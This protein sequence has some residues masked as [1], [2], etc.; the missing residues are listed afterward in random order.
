MNE[1]EIRRLI[2]IVEDTGIA[3][4]EVKKWWGMRVRIVRNGAYQFSPSA[5]P[6]QQ[7]NVIKL[8]GKA[9]EPEPVEEPETEYHIARS[10]MVGTFYRA[11]APGEEPFVSVGDSVKV[12]QT[13]CIIEAM[14]VMNE[15]EAECTGT[16]RKILI[17]N[18]QAV[19]F[20]QPLFY[21]D[22]SVS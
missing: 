4:L 2:K 16:I 13:L 5:V 20:N 15:I 18:A 22:E 7:E 21:I 8:P 3:E 17:E 12:G 14:K 9:Q 1:K 19:E 10:P 11:P 6:V